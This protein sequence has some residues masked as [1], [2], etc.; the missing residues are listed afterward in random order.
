M[1]MRTEQFAF[2]LKSSD[3]VSRN[4]LRDP[5]S[6]QANMVVGRACSCRLSSAHHSTKRSIRCQEACPHRV[7]GEPV[8]GTGWICDGARSLSAWSRS[9]PVCR[10]RLGEGRQSGSQSGGGS[11]AELVLIVPLRFAFNARR[12]N[13]GLYTLGYMLDRVDD[14]A[15]LADCIRRLLAEVNPSQRLRE[16]GA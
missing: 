9:P 13:F 12:H 10:R 3:G 5:F 4:S 11:I 7:Q 16:G 2:W 14:P 1:T 8:R 15:L 6:P